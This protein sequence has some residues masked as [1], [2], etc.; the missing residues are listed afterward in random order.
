MVQFCRFL[1]AA[2][3]FSVIAG[4]DSG[5][6]PSW[7]FRLPPDGNAERGKATFIALHCNNCHEVAGMDLGRPTVQPPVPV[8]LGGEVHNSLSDGYFVTAII[9]PSYELAHQPKNLIT[10]PTGESRMPPYCENITVRQLT[11]IVAFLKTRYV[12]RA[13]P[14]VTY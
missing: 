1:A 7:G 13:V 5:H 3:L 12:V 6:H 14:T 11:D 9:Y 2:A 4:C 8:V 10:T